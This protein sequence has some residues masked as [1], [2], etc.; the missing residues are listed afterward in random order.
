MAYSGSAN[1]QKKITGMLMQNKSLS[2]TSVRVPGSSS[3][4]HNL[5]TNRD[6]PDQHPM[7]AIT[8][9]ESVLATKFDDVEIVDGYMYLLSN[10]ERISGPHGP[11]AGG[12]GG[13]QNNAVVT[14]TNTT[15]WLSKTIADGSSCVLTASWTSLEGNIATGN[16][17]LSVKIGGATKLTRDV[18]QGDISVDIS[19]FLTSGTN[20]VRLVIMD[21]YGNS[22]S[23][24][25]TISV[26]PLSLASTFDASIPYSGAIT[27]T[28]IPTGNA[29]K[30]M[31]FKL[32]GTELEA[33]VV[34]VSGRQ[35]TYTIPAQSHGS[36][37]FEVWFTAEIDGQ[38]VASNHL[39]YD[40]ICTVDG[41]TAP[42]ISCAF[43]R[44]T[45]AQYE[46]VAIEWIAYS[47]ASL[48]SK[49]VLASNGATVSTQTVDRTKQT[50]NYRADSAG[51]LTLTI[52]CGSIVK[53]ITTTVEAT[54][55]DVE[56]VTDDLQLY[57][58][59]HGR[60]NNEANPGSWVSGDIACSFA[61]YNWASD[62]WQLDDNGITVHRVSGN[63]RLTI[64]LKI[65]SADFR[66]TGKTIE[67]E[68]ATRNVLNYDAT[69]L[70]CYSGGRGITLTAQ[71][72][73]LKSEQSEIST[74]YKENEHIRIAFVVEKRA[75]NR[76]IY[77]YING[78]MSGAV[79][80]PSD[81]DFS[82]AVP[83]D[84]TIGSN[85]CTV[86]LYN[87]R[88]YSNSLTRYQILDNW[89]A[90]T[91]NI[92]EKLARYERNHIFDAY[93]NV[94]IANLPSNLPYLVLQAPA[95][96][97]YKGNKLN[98]DGY[99][100]DPEDAQKCFEFEAAQA[101][102][103]GTSS[104]GYAR[105]NYKI[106]FKNG[107]ILNG[108]QSEGYK[109]RED[110]I[111]TNVFTF[112]ADV[113]SSEGAN[114]VE[115]V[116]LY[117]QIC[118]YKTPPQLL[119]A[120]VRQGI[121]G[122]PIVIF[123]DNGNGAVFV[124]KYNF[125]N[126]KGTPEVFGFASGDE[127]WEILNNTSNR[128]LFK[129]AD[130]TGTDWQNDF[131]AR[132]P[133]DSTAVE[134][135]A[136]FV[137]WIAS[138]D[139]STATGNALATSFVYDGTT[140]THDTAAYRLAKFKAEINNHAELTSSVF[141]YL[142][143]ELFLMVDSR[144]KNAFPSC[145]TGG[146]WCWLPYDFDTAIGINNEGALAFGY[147]L[148]DIDKTSGGANVFNGQ[149]SVFW[150]NLRAAFYENVRS[151][152]QQLRSDGV[153]S[154]A[155]IENAYEEHQNK[156]PEAIWNEDAWY[157]YLQ[158]LVEDN[159]A[160]YLSMLQGSKEQQRKW[161]LY[162]RFRYLD[163]KYNA[164]DAL[165]DFVTLRGYAKAN[166]S[167]EPYADIYAS[168]KFGSYL[169]QSRALRGSTY[170]LVCPLD[171]VNDTEIYIYSASQIKSMGDLSGLK[172]GYA[173]FSM[174]TK[175]Q[176][177]KV[178]D[179]SNTYSNENLTELYLGNNTLVQTLDARNC[180]NLGSGDIQQAVDLSGCT[181][182]ENVY[183]DG[184]TIKSC[185]LPN[186]GI[187]KVLHLPETITNLTIQNQTAI[188]D[189]T[190]PSY[191]NISTLRLENV[192][193]A[194]DCVAI[195]TA[196]S[197]TSRVRLT[198]VDWTLS[199]TTVLEKLLNMRGLS[200]TGDNLPNA[201]VSGNVHIA[202]TL[203][204]SNLVIYETA[205]P[206]LTITANSYSNNVL[207][208]TPEAVLLDSEGDMMKMSDGGYKSI[209]SHAQIEAFIEAVQEQMA[210]INSASKT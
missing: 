3:D 92:T 7:S 68:F 74:Q 39:Y 170:T 112:K 80:Y 145:F 43:K 183:F 37:T 73:V 129:S 153:L 99:Y 32:D 135:L 141:Y 30:I 159:T 169:V 108:A 114:N 181:N 21:A 132:Y 160:A 106:K 17:T 95:L 204:I 140:Y 25:F 178:G 118:P 207:M 12:G 130:F 173:D 85:D 177:I 44:G 81:D 48:T 4:N 46:N 180:P 186:G 97:T 76:L 87:I 162:N 63:A 152:Y 138:T 156:W 59:S 165:S 123:H 13:S 166:I 189:F 196:I 147:E 157:K 134:K 133:E 143:T 203:P 209:Y 120:S 11:F 2:G 111:P 163:S 201:V 102:V 23:L 15:G 127:S 53:I 172:V 51:A 35:Q 27:Y 57:L 119:N 199:A 168:V 42:I 202:G 100:T 116:R 184:T 205:F 78:I 155:V 194:V 50:W 136:S 29:A 60:S 187:L 75:E 90:D 126:D 20:A 54:E 83:V 171:N 94:V 5:L 62:G 36:H 8:G 70:S 18:A 9:L 28:Y 150:V 115:L 144:A 10:G 55:I 188:T 41:N 161:W 91:Q 65:F 56:A 77:I 22:R 137:A 96:P 167:I 72:A 104:A 16:G 109:L 146:K 64:P 61:G 142:F 158:P 33:V 174:A 176:F 47:P 79:Q 6:L 195:L 121:D 122:F 110:S 185:S 89:I 84:I 179:A 139:Q 101:D 98:V 125:N 117:N 14:F 66:S 19:D 113:A 52:T 193:A 49:V 190:I 34:N 210:A 149:S 206:Y 69:V 151:M 131:E 82:Q 192:S 128:V 154:Y 26:A 71:K 105:K 148:E 198:N 124:G 197:E 164:G 45:I 58:S 24:N 1:A 191:E 86:D 31:H 175:V 67:V 38:T 200:E 93:G 88:I 208:V 40:L 103:Q 182:I 107:V